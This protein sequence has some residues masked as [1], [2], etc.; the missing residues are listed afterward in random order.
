MEARQTY[1]AA[2]RRRVQPT[3]AALLSAPAVIATSIDA[4]IIRR[5]VVFNH[6]V[7]LRQATADAHAGM[8]ALLR[9]F[10]GPAGNLAADWEGEEWPPRLLTAEIEPAQRKHQ[11][12]GRFAFL[13]AV[14]DVVPI[15]AV[16]DR[17]EGRGGRFVPLAGM[18]RE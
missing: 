11:S 8:H 18:H 15:I 2:V 1:G 7:R 5:A 14:I 9:L 17:D 12:E 6:S 10:P 4:T 16:L 13:V 3:A